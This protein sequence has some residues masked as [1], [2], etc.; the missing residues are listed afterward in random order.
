VIR[1]FR[2]EPADRESGSGARV[3]AEA[4]KRKVDLRTPVSLGDRL[5]A[6]ALIAP[7]QDQSES[8]RRARHGNPRHGPGLTSGDPASVGRD[9]LTV[10][11]VARPGFQHEFTVTPRPDG[12][13]AEVHGNRV[14][15]PFEREKEADRLRRSRRR[16]GGRRWAGRRAANAHVLINRDG[17]LG[18]SAVA[19]E[20]DPWLD[21][22][23]R[24]T[25]SDHR[26][27]ILGASPARPPKRGLQGERCPI[28]PAP[29]AA[30]AR[31]ALWREAGPADRCNS[32]AGQR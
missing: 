26:K 16:A 13:V 32:E 3:A 9:R 20:V 11:G 24:G 2:F 15:V 8:R 31:F 1:V 25:R 29:S 17:A 12:L 30:G 4:T 5:G 28:R 18:Q 10:S 14:P 19:T 7:A 27:G 23:G 6:C 22:N 21:L